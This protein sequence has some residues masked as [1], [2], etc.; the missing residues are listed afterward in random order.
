[1]ATRTELGDVL[2][3]SQRRTASDMADAR[4][5][6]GGAEMKECPT[7]GTDSEILRVRTKRS[8]HSRRKEC[9]D[10]SL[11]DKDEL[12][13]YMSKLPGYLQR[14]DRGEE[15]VP[16]SNVL[17]VGVLDWDRLEKWKRGRAR[18]GKSERHVSSCGFATTSTSGVVVPNESHHKCEIDDQFPTCSNLGKVK[19]FRDLQHSLEPVLASRDSLNKQEIET[20]SSKPSGRDHKAVEPRKSRRSHSN[21]ESSS[22]LLSEM[23]NSGGSLSMKKNLVVRDRDTQKRAGERATESARHCVEKKFNEASTTGEKQEFSNIFLLRS[24]K[25]SQSSTLSCEPQSLDDNMRGAREANRSCPLSIDLE[26]YSEDRMLPLGAELSGKKERSSGRRHSKTASRIFDQEIREDES[27]KER[28]HSPSKRFSFSFGRLSRSFSVKE[29]SDGQPS[30]DAFKSSSMRF[31]GSVCPSQSSNPESHNTHCRSRVSPLRRFLDPLLK[32]KGSENVL[33]SKA[34]SSS[35]NPNPTKS[36]IQLQDEKKQDTSRTRALFQLTIR[37]G[38]P[39]FQFVVEDNN[40]S[41]SRSILGGS[42]KSS[43]FKDDSVQ[44]C[45]FY[46]VNEV[47]KK[48]SGSW[49]IHGHKEKHCGFVYNLIGQMRLSNSMSSD[50]TEQKFRIISPVIRESVLFDES[51]QVKGRKE[52]AAVVIKKKP[53]EE[54]CTGLEETSVII[55]GGVH[56]FPEK[57]APSPLISRWRSGGLCDCGGWDVGCKLHVLSNKSHLHEFNQ[58]FEL[59]DQEGSEQESG[60]ALAMIELK[61]GIYRVEF[62]PLVSPLQAFFVCVTVI[63]CASEAKTTVKSSSPLAP[64]LSPVGRV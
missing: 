2:K 5:H 34:R 59:L 47:K 7:S 33:P 26:K 29:D 41:S 11:E 44:Y 54:N 63:T 52:V 15:S 12:V 61:T 28:H 56:S 62:G 51:E 22:G 57:G 48:K 10:E 35:S 53:V 64:P 37:N 49:L 58:T 50:L 38:I 21:Q 32:P 30:Q 23:G 25:Q 36:D 9:V 16:Q 42:M 17:N 8:S 13:K 60:P 45:T 43:S 31:D 1:M 14:V 24:R 20:C 6:K 55:P 3:Q 46:S 4:L 27:R 39:L 19:A 40:N 18:S